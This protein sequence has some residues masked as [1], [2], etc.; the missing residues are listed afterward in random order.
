MF[1]KNPIRSITSNPHNLA[2][3]KHFYTIQG[4]GPYSGMPALFIR[5]SGCN[6]ACHF[7]DT[8][9]EENVNTLIN[10]QTF[11]D[12]LLATYT[13]AQ[14]KFVVITGGEPMRQ[15]FGGLANRLL[16]TGTKLIQ[17][18][19][20][21]TL[22]QPS[23]EG[24]IMI[25]NVV[26]VCSPKTPKVHPRIQSLCNHWKYIITA[27]EVASDDGLPNR[28]TH[29]STKTQ[30]IKVYRPQ[31]RYEPFAPAQTVWVSPCD[32]Y[33]S[34]MNYNNMY[35]TRDSALRFGYRLSLQVHKL[36]GVE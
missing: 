5:L 14:R 23:L 26:L 21:G 30:E 3:E 17:V 16:T 6:L 4:E 9:F 36:I 28:G 29:E 13:T 32:S 20:A 24:Q 12:E 27:G 8:Q 2:V 25:G 1:G 19:T 22:W 33:D 35:A 7:C 31:T 10:T 34:A 15:N 11:V 18:E